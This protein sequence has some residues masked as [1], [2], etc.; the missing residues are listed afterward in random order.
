MFSRIV[1][2]QL[3]QTTFKRP[4]FFIAARPFAR[5]FSSYTWDEEPGQRQVPWEES[6]TTHKSNAE[7]LIN[8]LPVI[9]V[10]GDTVRCSGVNELG[11]GH[12]VHYMTVDQRNIETP[13]VCKWCGLRYVKKAG[14]HA[15]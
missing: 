8:K 11:Y 9:E 13:V 7:E 5:A 6:N 1:R 4:T 15:H 10:E 12:P 2:R 3:Y 14:A